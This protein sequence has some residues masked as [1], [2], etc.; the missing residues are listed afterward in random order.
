MKLKLPTP[1]EKRAL[2][3]E[4]NVEALLYALDSRLPDKTTVMLVGRAS[5]EIGDKKL[6]EKLKALLNEE[7]RVDERTRKIRLTDDVDCYHTDEA[8]AIIDIGH[9]QSYVAL[10]ADCYVHALNERTLTLPKG[11]QERIQPVLGHKFE[12]LEIKRLDPLDFV[13]CKGAAG[14][15]KDVKFL[16]AFCEALSIGQQSVAEKINATLSDPTPQLRLDR[17]SQ[18]NLKMLVGRLF[19]SDISDRPQLD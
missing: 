17:G 4:T 5:Y 16:R 10:L 19:P 12:K 11:W 7:V 14:R 1:E 18:I 8:Q 2:P 15:P 9:Q 13:V 6:T 3:G